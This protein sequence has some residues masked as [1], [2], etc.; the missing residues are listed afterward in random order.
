MQLIL[1]NPGLR[2]RSAWGGWA[3]SAILHGAL[4]LLLAFALPILMTDPIPPAEPVAVDL[5]VT[6]GDLGPTSGGPE[7][8]KTPESRP[9]DAPEAE[10]KPPEPVPAHRPSPA[11]PRRE[12]VSDI[13]PARKPH[14]P[15]PTPPAVAPR[16]GTAPA[17]TAINAGEGG[18]GQQ[19]RFSVKDFLRAQIERHWNFDPS[20]LGRNSV[21][22][23]IHVRL[24]PDGSVKSADV[25]DDPRYDSNP[26]YQSV[27]DSARRAVLVS[28]PLQLPAGTYDS[29]RD[30]TL[31][32]DPREAMQ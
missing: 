1:A 3:C 32:F 5:V 29:V 21:V 23:S 28:S 8:A 2:R 11:R 9:P 26:S 14:H 4:A 18:G 12:P 25:V 17:T 10:A 6:P 13:K 16:N 19:G 22:V 31:S 7:K 20:S 15:Q 24:E 30:V 27:A